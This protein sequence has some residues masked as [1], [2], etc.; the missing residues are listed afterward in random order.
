MKLSVSEL[1]IQC[2]LILLVVPLVVVFLSPTTDALSMGLYWLVGV[3][4]A[5]LGFW[6]IRWLV[7][8]RP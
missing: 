3:G 8:R 1:V 7:R 4:I 6:C 5:E 2:I